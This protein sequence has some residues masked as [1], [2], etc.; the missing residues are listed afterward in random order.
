MLAALMAIAFVCGLEQA[1]PYRLSV[2]AGGIYVIVRHRT[3]PFSGDWLG[4]SHA[5]CKVASMQKRDHK[6]LRGGLSETEIAN[7]GCFWLTNANVCIVKEG[8]PH[9]HARATF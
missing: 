2:I 1:L 6:F 4:Q 8:N 7:I 3:N 9:V 5:W